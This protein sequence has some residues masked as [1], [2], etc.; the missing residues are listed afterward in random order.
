MNVT[1]YSR[2]NQLSRED[3]SKYFLSDS[4][5][6][7]NGS[8]QCSFQNETFLLDNTEALNHEK[9]QEKNQGDEEIGDRSL[10]G[11]FCEQLEITIT[12]SKLENSRAN[13]G[14]EG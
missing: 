2:V 7:S 6:N 12:E 3:F 1:N 11:D 9:R 14:E 10:F 13:R 4:K 8:D 5:A